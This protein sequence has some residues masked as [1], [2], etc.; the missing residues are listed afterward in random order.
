MAKTNAKAKTKTDWSQ[1]FRFIKQIKLDWILILITLV[2]TIVYYEVTALIPDATAGLLAGDFTATA[3]WGC[4]GIYLVQLVLNVVVSLLDTFAT[5]RSTRNAR[6]VIWGKMMGVQTKFYQDNTPEQMLSAV[7][8]DTQAAVSS[9]VMLAS[10]TIP[11]VYYMIRS[12]SIVGGY[13]WKLLMTLL[14]MVP[15]NVLYAIYV[16][17]WQHKTNSRIQNR[18]GGLTGYLAERLKNLS[19]IKSFATEKTEDANGQKTIKELYG[20]KK[21][22]IYI[23][24]LSVGYMMGTEVIS[25]VA[26]VLIAS[27]LLRNGEL[28]LEGWM[29]F[30]M[31]MPK[32]GAVLRQICN[33]WITVKGIQGYSERLGKIIDAPQEAESQGENVAVGDIS[34]ENVS[35]AYGEEKVLDNVSF[36]APAGCVTAIVGLSGSG[37]STMLNMVERL[38]TPA[39]GTITMN[40]ADIAKLD[41]NGYRSSIAYVP[42]DAG[43]FSGSYRD[44]L[45]Y[46][47]QETVSDEDLVR[48]TKLVGIYDYIAA[49]PDGFD[50]VI[51]L[52][53]N[54]LSGGQRQR[55]VIAREVLKDADVLL[56]D[57]PTSSLDAATAR[58]IQNT[59][60]NVFKGKTILMVSHDL[61]LVG[62]ADKIVVVDQGKIV[63]SGTHC[64]LMKSCALYKDLV[65]EQAYQEVY[66]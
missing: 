27:G 60:L 7:T 28:T 51:S 56:F 23:N 54:S 47:V 41:L 29:A 6:K 37:K 53:G 57:E 31:Y 58:E 35:F 32:I 5:A 45:T 40:G 65:D 62:T 12:F 18:I 10:G 22:S 30:Y 3:I 59:I 48:V 8:S 20:A 24:S 25:I 16:G 66:A 38:Y 63:S 61:A 64:D 19:L 50:A 11:M 55:L 44:V 33:T 34:F 4:V 49:Q 36:T 26:A 1:F 15:V 39:A 9:I 2:V 52:W 13:N 14:V 17:K 46:G 43:V 21:H 42:Q